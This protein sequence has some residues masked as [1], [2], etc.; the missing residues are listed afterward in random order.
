MTI[1]LHLERF[2]YKELL[3]MNDS[4]NFFIVVVEIT[5]SL[6]RLQFP[7]VLLIIENAVINFV[8]CMVLLHIYYF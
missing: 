7:Y 1:C 8:T 3:G 2:L 5:V 6:H 4:F